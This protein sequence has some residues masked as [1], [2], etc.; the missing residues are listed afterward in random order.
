[1]NLL[2]EQDCRRGCAGGQTFHGCV[3]LDCWL[4]RIGTTASLA[5]EGRFKVKDEIRD[6]RK[7]DN[8][9]GLL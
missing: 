2:D 3:W 6:N 8:M 7:K 9:A 4:S 1:M 5:K